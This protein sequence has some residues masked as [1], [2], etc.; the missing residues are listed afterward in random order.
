MPRGG[1]AVGEQREAKSRQRLHPPGPGGAKLCPS[2]AKGGPRGNAGTR[3]PQLPGELAGAMVIR[4][5]SAFRGH[6]ASASSSGCGG[7]APQGRPWSVSKRFR[8]FPC[9][10]SAA[11]GQA[12]SSPGSTGLRSGA[13]IFTGALLSKQA[14]HFPGVGRTGEREQRPARAPEPESHPAPSE[15]ALWL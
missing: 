9:L 15:L 8:G 2:R 1:T 13:H 5:A 4:C 14:H 11:R 7:R 10:R 12:W 6:W 3:K